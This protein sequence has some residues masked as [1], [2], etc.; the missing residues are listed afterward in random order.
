MF[1][2]L[3]L[4]PGPEFTPDAA[5]ALASTTVRQASALLDQ[6]AAAHMIESRPGGR[7]GFHDLVRL[8]ARERADA[9]DTPA[10][11]HLARQRLFNHYLSIASAAHGIVS[12]QAARL[13]ATMEPLPPPSI[14]RLDYATAMSWLDDERANLI[15]AIIYGAGHDFGPTAWR[16]AY[17]LRAYMFTHRLGD[18][19][20]SAA[21]AALSAATEDGDHLGQAAMHLSL[22]ISHGH[23]GNYRTATEQFGKAGAC[24]RQVGWRTGESS[25]LSG[26][27]SAE[28]CLGM[29]DQAITHLNQSLD[30]GRELGSLSDQARARANLAYCL[31]LG[32]RLTDSAECSRQALSIYSEFSYPRGWCLAMD[33]LG[34]AL[35]ALGDPEAALVA[36]T[37]ALGSGR[38]IGSKHQQSLALCHIAAVH[39]DAHRWLPA[40]ECAEE[41][42]L[43]ARTAGDHDGL[44]EALV[45]YAD[46]LAGLGRFDEADDR[47]A[48]V[49]RAAAASGFVPAGV[50]ARIGV[51]D[52]RTVQ[53]RPADA[54]ASAREALT[55]ADKH[56]LRV[57]EGRALTVLA[58][59]TA[60]AGRPREAAAHADR[61]R[62]VHG[63]TG[64]RLDDERLAA[65][66][67]GD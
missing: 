30:I 20:L 16:L 60:R 8:Y 55:I 43:L 40:Q 39:R 56:G 17:A 65:L 26:L 46:V 53:D 19:W 66:A 18:D 33:N 22:G 41:A 14:G 5:A 23:L 37:E 54:I 29:L 59:A 47:Y 48:E 36:H 4:V 42:L 25:A 15:A 7:F 57:C 9:E 2:L 28:Y 32:G 44:G 38:Q 63:R 58:E 50:D 49:V 52:L 35:R 31:L 1:R 64:Y 11:R 10:A 13:P 45:V 61:A 12:P 3:G 6:L 51:A 27:G 21:H 62:A 67:A 34:L 24:C